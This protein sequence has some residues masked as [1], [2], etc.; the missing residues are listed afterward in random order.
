MKEVLS[1]SGVPYVYVDICEQ[2]A[3]LRAFLMIRDTSEA[4]AP[5]REAHTIG[6]PTLV[7]DD[8]VMLVQGPDHA[9]QL[10]EELHLAE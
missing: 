7:V 2:V 10:I 8:Q 1:Q 4:H 6:I 5:V 3:N 9:R